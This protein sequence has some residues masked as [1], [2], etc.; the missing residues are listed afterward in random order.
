[1]TTMMLVI[2]GVLVIE[3][4]GPLLFPRQWKKMLTELFQ[5]ETPVLRR[6]GGAMVT[7]GL[8]LFYI[9]ST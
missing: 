5:L 7:A 4:L 2:A 9:F 3:G 6:F 8:V 1:M